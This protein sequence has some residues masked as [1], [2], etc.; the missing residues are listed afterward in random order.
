MFPLTRPGIE[1]PKS[2]GLRDESWYA[3]G[4]DKPSD[5]DTPVVPENVIITARAPGSKLVLIDLD[6]AHRRF[7]FCELSTLLGWASTTLT[8]PPPLRAGLTLRSSR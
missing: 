1:L 8:N 7:R 2:G 6:D 4:F 3:L 5:P